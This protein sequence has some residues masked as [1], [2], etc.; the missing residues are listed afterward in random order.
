MEIKMD[1]Q[2]LSQLSSFNVS[3]KHL[4]IDSNEKN[5]NLVKNFGPSLI[6]DNFILRSRLKNAKRTE[7]LPEYFQHYSQP[8][9][10]T[11][12]DADTLRHVCD[13]PYIPPTLPT[14]LIPIS[15]RDAEKSIITT[16]S[17]EINMKSADR[18]KNV[19]LEKDSL[20]HLEVPA[21]ISLTINSRQL[22]VTAEKKSNKQKLVEKEENLENSLEELGSSSVNSYSIENEAMIPIKSI[23]HMSSRKSRLRKKVRFPT[24]CS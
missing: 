8:F 22:N 19:L 13:S 24:E 6:L 4:S 20:E 18:I 9:A 21:K 10:N 5:R 16:K 14:S 1:E 7:A 2:I 11:F 3:K 23:L 12:N 15:L 17:D